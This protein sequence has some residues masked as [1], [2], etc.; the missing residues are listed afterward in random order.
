MRSEKSELP[1]HFM[2]G[3]VAVQDYNSAVAEMPH[4]M[5]RQNVTLLK[6]MRQKSW[7]Y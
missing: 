7:G 6:K 1:E 2:R 3:P 5:T 4:L